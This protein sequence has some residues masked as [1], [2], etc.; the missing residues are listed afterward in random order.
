MTLI[1]K[2]ENALFSGDCILG[3]GTTMFE[4]LEDYMKS[5]QELLKIKPDVIYPGA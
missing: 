5:L 3:E 2:E 4:N 1:L